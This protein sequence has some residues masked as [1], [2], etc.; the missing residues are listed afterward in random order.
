MGNKQ[1][2]SK[3]S[4]RHKQSPAIDETQPAPSQQKPIIP[5]P[6]PPSQNTKKEEKKSSLT[7]TTET[8]EDG[9]GEY[10]II[11]AEE[12]DIDS[13]INDFIPNELL[14]F[15]FVR[16]IEE[17]IDLFLNIQTPMVVIHL[18]QSFF[19]ISFNYQYIFV[20]FIERMGYTKASGYTNDNSIKSSQLIIHELST[21]KNIEIKFDGQNK[22]YFFKPNRQID[23]DS[24]CAI[25]N[26]SIPQW[27][28]NKQEYKSYFD[29]IGGIYFHFSII[30]VIVI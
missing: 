15:G 8:K 28:Q 20:A 5:A 4:S 12:S 24:Y 1:A 27:M 14:L 19:D 30:Y 2:K 22:K 25:S 13:N 10:E 3:L 23:Q 16:E 26:I 29:Q 18:I 7:N 6:I 17:N 21:K 11:A 9:N